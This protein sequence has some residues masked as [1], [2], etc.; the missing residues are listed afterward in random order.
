MRGRELIIV[1]VPGHPVHIPAI[2]ILKSVA[3][4]GAKALFQVR[5]R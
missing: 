1:P 2:D 4:P 5:S 3:L